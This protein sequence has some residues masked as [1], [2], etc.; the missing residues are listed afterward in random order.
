MFDTKLNSLE[1]ADRIYVVDAQGSVLDKTPRTQQWNKAGDYGSYR[2]DMSEDL[3]SG[4]MYRLVIDE[5]VQ[6]QEGITIREKREIPF[7]PIQFTE[8]VLEKALNCSA[9][10]FVYDEEQSV[11]VES[12]KVSVTNKNREY[13]FVKS[14][15]LTY[16]F[17]ENEAI[18]E[19]SLTSPIAVENSMELA[20]PLKGDF[21]HNNL[22]LKYVNE[23]ATDS[24]YVDLLTLN[25]INWYVYNVKVEGLPT[26]GKRWYLSAIAIE[27]TGHPANAFESEIFIENIY[28]GN[29]PINVEQVV[30]DGVRVWPNPAAEFIYVDAPENASVEV[31]SVDGRMITAIPANS[32]SENNLIR[33]ID[34]Y[35]L[36]AGVYV[37]NITTANG[38][39]SLKFVKE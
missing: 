39:Q 17:D 10:A 20:M 8:P 36:T 16:A 19:Y 18:V 32:A 6:N 34:T 9:V 24:I 15:K 5:Y 29:V 14:N 38:T 12:A 26:D 21:S 13:L 27:K 30:G 2:F 1:C 33:Q 22:Q 3:K 23:D 35:N 7:I 11:G 25:N 4:E 37:V 28:F 31:Y